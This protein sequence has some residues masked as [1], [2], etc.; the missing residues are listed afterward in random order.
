MNIFVLD[1]DPV[2]AAQTQCD[3][4]VVKMIVESAQMLCTA[5]RL[6]DGNVSIVQRVSPKTGKMRKAKIWQIKDSPLDSV[7][8]QVCHQ[9]H[10]C[11]LWSVECSEN[12]E[13]HYRHFI[14]LCDE[15]E[16]RYGK[17]H[18]TR[19]KLAD[20]LRALP[21]NISHGAITP[22]R[23]AMKSNPECQHTDDPVRSYREFYQTKQSR[24]KMK[25]TKR[26]VPNWFI[27]KHA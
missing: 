14:A 18:A 9:N 7:L 26:E 10:P 20:A 21:K 17:V 1:N 16:L 27:L 24:F 15:Y 19:R 4:H 2:I 11:T 12:Y 25:W 22:F 6:L 3:K 23:L 13:W 8:Y 5:H